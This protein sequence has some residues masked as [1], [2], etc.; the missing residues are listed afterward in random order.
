[1]LLLD[2][3]L[4]LPAWVRVL[5]FVGW[6]SLTVFLGFTALV[7]PLSRPL[8]PEALAA[9]IEEKYPDLGERLTSA[10]ELSDPSGRTHGAP[11]LIALLFQE[12][13]A[14][15]ER[16]NF[17]RAFPARWVGGWPSSRSS[18]WRSPCP[19]PTSGPAA[20]WTEPAFLLALHTPEAGCVTS[21][22][23]PPG[24][25]FA[26]KGRPLTSVQVAADGRE[27]LAARH[28]HPR[29]HDDQGTVRR[30][31]RADRPDA[32]SFELDKVA[33]DFAYRVEAGDTASETYRVTAVEPVELGDGTAVA[34]TPP[35][36]PRR[37]WRRS[38]WTPSPTWPRCSIAG[39]ASR[40]ASPGPRR[41]PIWNGPRPARTANPARPPRASSS[42]WSCPPTGSGRDG[43]AAGQETGSYKL[44]L[45]A[46]HGIR[47]RIAARPLAVPVDQPPA[48]I[49][50]AGTERPK[51]EW[52]VEPDGTGTIFRPE[53]EQPRETSK[54]S[55]RT[56]A[57]P[58]R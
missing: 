4:D 38:S 21:S 46:E 37:P 8:R 14:R 45:E 43:R 35:D 49:N 22:K 20:T 39:S 48:F 44:V 41:P 9:L 28:L 29:L 15:T 6:W 19:P 24:D 7:L 10:V 17:L 27:R 56:T 52:R 34:V 31:M 36:T 11:A 3:W 13:E 53:G 23:S 58:W 12:T 5:V 18:G 1:M 33:G 57:C 42:P 2:A 50:V 30:L 25:T 32:F 16:L 54:S 40:F 26:G 51:T 47:T 55:C